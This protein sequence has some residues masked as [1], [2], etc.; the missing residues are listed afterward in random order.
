MSC[1]YS[2][3]ISKFNFLIEIE[4]SYLE[5]LPFMYFSYAEH[6]FHKCSIYGIYK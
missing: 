4:T 3:N 1:D 2:K 5:K 6:F